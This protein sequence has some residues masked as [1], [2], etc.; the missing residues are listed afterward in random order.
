MFIKQLNTSLCSV[1][2]IMFRCHLNDL[3]LPFCI[4]HTTYRVASYLT[5]EMLMYSIP[6]KFLSNVSM[7]LAP[8]PALSSHS[9]SGAG[10][11]LSMGWICGWKAAGD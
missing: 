6:F 1:S 5:K 7:Q 10:R 3:L 4:G 8:P 9:L 11:W 2:S